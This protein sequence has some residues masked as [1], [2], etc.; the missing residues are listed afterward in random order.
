[1]TF[2][3]DKISRHVVERDLADPQ[4][5]AFVHFQ[6][7]TNLVRS[8]SDFRNR[9]EAAIAASF[10]SE[11]AE[12]RGGGCAPCNGTAAIQE[13]FERQARTTGDRY[14][15]SNFKVT[16][17]TATF[18]QQV[19]FT[20]T[21]PFGVISRIFV[22]ITIQL[23]E[24]KITSW[25]FVSDLTDPETALNAD[26]S[27]LNAVRNQYE[28]AV[29]R[30]DIATALTFLTEDTV[31]EDAATCRVAPCVGKEAVGAALERRAATVTMAA[32]GEPQF[33]EVV[34]RVR[35]QV[36]GAEFEAA[37]VQRVINVVEWDGRSV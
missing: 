1:M 18:R 9:G 17:N 5:A 14:T 29:N 35:A 6:N 22:D 24:G 23:R 30:G 27:R 28:A 3:G 32:F 37:G 15:V 36:T 21:H 7:V 25:R 13:L 4:T 34:L 12:F 10:F 31:R 26:I 11:D 16:G 8:L 20:G 33:S 2:S 19:D